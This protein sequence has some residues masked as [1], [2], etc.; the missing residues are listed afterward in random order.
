VE[1]L[2]QYKLIIAY[3]GTDYHGWQMQYH[4]LSVTQVLQ[5]TFKK[6]FFKDITIVGASRTDA[7]VHAVGQVATFTTDMVIDPIAMRKAW[8]SIL[9]PS[10]LIRSAER[11]DGSFHSQRNVK[12]KTYYYHFFSERPLPFLARYGWFFHRAVSLE[13]LRDCLQVFVGTHDFRSFCT[14]DD[15]QKNTIRTIDEISV[16][17]ISKFKVVRIRV[18]GHSFLHYMIRR[19]VGAALTVASHDHLDRSVLEKALA[20]KNPQQSLP[21]A[22]AQGLMLYKIKYQEEK[23]EL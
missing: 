2:H 4:C 17:Y 10:I 16:A 8:N 14:L 11:V 6:V 15:E 1:A 3:D 9:P 7:G 19:I 22:P 5:D 12:Q 20:E 18:R 21:K 13:K 23:N